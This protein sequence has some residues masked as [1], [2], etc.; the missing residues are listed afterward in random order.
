[1][2]VRKGHP[3]EV[4]EMFLETVVQVRHKALGRLKRSVSEQFKSTVKLPYQDF[5]TTILFMA[6]IAV[7]ITYPYIEQ[8]IDSVNMVSGDIDSYTIHLKG[9][10][11]LS[12]CEEHPKHHTPARHELCIAY[13]SIFEAY[14]SAHSLYRVL[15]I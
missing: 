1:M 8:W 3:K 7:R 5:L 2:F 11:S 9:V 15:S 14:M 12:E 4:A 13:T 6:F 10:N